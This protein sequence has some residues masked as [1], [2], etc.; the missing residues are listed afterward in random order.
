MDNISKDVFKAVE[1]KTG[2]QVPKQALNRI[3]QGV[4]SGTLQSDAQLRSLIMQVAKAVNVPVSKTTVNQIIKAVKQSGG[5]LSS[6]ES[7]IKALIKK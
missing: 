5:N 3:A 7:L 1:G 4:S 2:K 6:L